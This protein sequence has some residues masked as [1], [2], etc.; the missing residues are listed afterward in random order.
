MTKTKKQLRAEAVERL[1]NCVAARFDA[2]SIVIAL[3]SGRHGQSDWSLEC[4]KLIDLLT[5]DDVNDDSVPES[6]VSDSEPFLTPLSNPNETGNGDDS[7]EKLE[8]D[9]FACLQQAYITYPKVIELLDRQAAITERKCRKPNW[10]YCETCETLAELTAERDELKERADYNIHGWA[11]ANIGWAEANAEV[12]KWQM[13]CDEYRSKF[14]KCID[15]ADAI[16]AL[17]DDEGLA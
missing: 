6:G 12:E 9:V 8:A 16:H 17:M 13:K 11:K 14:G 7:R 15:H 3:T 1:K 10:D 5:D 2:E 4:D